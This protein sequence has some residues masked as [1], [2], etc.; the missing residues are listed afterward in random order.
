[1]EI[2]HFSF[3]RKNEM[4]N[5]DF[6]NQQFTLEKGPVSLYA[7]FLVGATGAPTLQVPGSKGIQSIFR[8]AVGKYTIT[9]GTVGQAV[10]TYQQLL[11][12]NYFS[13]F[14]TPASVNCFVTQDNSSNLTAPTVVIQFQS[15][16][17]TNVELANGEDIR[18]EFEMRN[19]TAI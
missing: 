6:C 14:S 19:S 4:A 5:R 9:F 7:R 17:G 3:E 16:A 18:L 11:G 1:M 15:A 13:V 2:S 8:N 12:F 10:D